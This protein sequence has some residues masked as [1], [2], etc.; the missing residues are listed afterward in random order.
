VTLIIGMRC[1]DGSVVCAD[2]QETVGNYRLTVQKIVPERIGEYVVILAG[3]GIGELIDGFIGLFKERILASKTTGLSIFKEVFEAEFARYRKEQVPLYNAQKRYKNMQFIVAAHLN[4]TYEL[5][6]TKGG[7]LVP[8]PYYCLIGVTEPLYGEVLDRLYN[9]NIDVAQAVLAGI[10]TLGVAESTSQYVRGPMQ[11]G[12]VNNFG[13]WIDGKEH[14]ANS[15]GRLK[16][17]EQ[18]VNSLMLASADIGMNLAQY[19]KLLEAFTEDAMRLHK[20]AIIEAARRFLSEPLESFRW[21]NTAYNRIP[22]ALSMTIQSGDFDDILGPGEKADLVA[23][24]T[25]A[26]KVAY[27]VE[28]T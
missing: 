27:R 4:G 26:I 23:K 22:P 9:P 3:S 19:G 25:E 14:S 7:K 21:I 5:W 20:Q 10:Y 18:R 2:S 15:F 11:V 24:M 6:T 13:A 12:G 17:M 16:S 8:I 28:R 1:S